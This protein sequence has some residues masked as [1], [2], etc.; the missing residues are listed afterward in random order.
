MYR[1]QKKFKKYWDKLL[2]DHLPPLAKL[3]KFQAEMREH[4]GFTLWMIKRFVAPLVVFYVIAGILMQKNVF[5][6]LFISL[7]IF[8]YSNVI[9]DIDMLIK[10]AERG[11]ESP[12]YEKYFLLFFA[13]LIVYYILDGKAHPILDSESRPFHNLRTVLAYATFLFIVGNIFWTESLKILMLPVF[14]ALGFI[15]HLMVDVGWLQ[16]KYKN[17]SIKNKADSRS[18]PNPTG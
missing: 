5:G 8:I 11:Q 9:P 13:P 16:Q 17:S 1:T 15:F 14:G 18:E 7:L 4:F 3:E 2:S 6:S 10:K 12:W